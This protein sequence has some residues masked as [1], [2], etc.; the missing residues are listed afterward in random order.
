M[1]ISYLDNLKTFLIILVVAHHAALSYQLGAAN[2]LIPDPEKTKWIS[3]LIT[4]NATF[5]MGLFFLIS[6]YFLPGSYERSPAWI[7]IKK[8]L[9]RLGIPTLFTLFF[10]L[11]PAF[12]F[13][14]QGPLSFTDFYRYWF[15]TK[16]HFTW[17]HTWFIIQ[18]LIYSIFYIVCRKLYP[19][20]L[21]PSQHFSLTQ[22][23]IV[24]Y[25]TALFLMTAIMNLW[26]PQDRWTLHHLFEPYHLPQY[27][28]LFFIG[29]LAFENKWLETLNRPMGY[30]W[31]MIGILCFGY[32]ALHLETQAP[33]FKTLWSSLMCPAWCIGLLTLFRDYM[34][35]TGPLLQ[36]L[37]AN[38]Y[39]V[40]LVHVVV[41]VYIQ[42]LLVPYT[43]WSIWEKF[44]IT[45]VI[46]YL[47]SNLICVL[48][49]KIPLI[50]RVL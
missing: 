29:I 38:A 42:S 35:K 23:K 46:G 8:K 47:G 44:T 43:Q 3:L 40:Y 33:L 10:I 17:G 2:W 20:F 49:R 31:L 6:G 45:F 26:F 1:K 13:S 30:T 9:I 16:A 15:L 25:T 24:L 21:K 5:F 36:S 34:N 50:R 37:S 12:Y 14:Y 4:S 22:T 11:P 41:V 32:L 28:S 27:V 39:A 18:L 48:L 19:S 7:L